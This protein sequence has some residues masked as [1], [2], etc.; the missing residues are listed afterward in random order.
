LWQRRERARPPQAA[1]GAA[2]TATGEDVTPQAAGFGTAGA[3]AARFRLDG[4]PP[5]DYG[6]FVGTLI[7]L[8]WWFFVNVMV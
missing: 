8:F 6:E 2:A 4:E 1:G 3:M 7:A 5:P